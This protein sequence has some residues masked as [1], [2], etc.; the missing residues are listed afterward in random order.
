MLFAYSNQG[1]KKIL[2]SLDQVKKFESES[3]DIILCHNVLE[4]IDENC[5]VNYLAELKRVLK[6]MGSYLLLNIIKLV[7]LCNQLSF[8]MML[9]KH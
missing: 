3:F 4:Y 5:R 6:Q 1:Y 2:G 7:K 9:I 8:Q